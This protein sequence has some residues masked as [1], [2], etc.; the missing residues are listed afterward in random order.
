MKKQTLDEFTFK[1]KAKHGDRYEYPADQAY[2][3]TKSKV[4]IKCPEH[5]LFS[6]TA[7][8]HLIGKGCPLCGNKIKKKLSISQIIENL[9]VK[10]SDKFE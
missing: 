1:A 10:H 8:N 2:E 9:K 6:Q 4:T 5:G 7:Y 3:G